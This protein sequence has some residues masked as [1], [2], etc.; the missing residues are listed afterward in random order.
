MSARNVSRNALRKEY[1]AMPHPRTR[2]IRLRN[3]A[4][5]RGY[6]LHKIRRHDPLATDFGSGGCEARAPRAA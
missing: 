3:T 2:E 4:M 1:W 6:T 5:R